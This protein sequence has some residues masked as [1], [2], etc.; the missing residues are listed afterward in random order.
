MHFLEVFTCTVSNIESMNPDSLIR[1]LATIN[2]KKSGR[3]ELKLLY[4]KI[5]A[6]VTS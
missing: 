6:W 5:T 2:L 3:P 1:L 4:D